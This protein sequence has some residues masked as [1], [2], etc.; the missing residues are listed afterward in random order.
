M[1]VPKHV[2]ESQIASEIMLSQS[3]MSR[4]LSRTPLTNVLNTKIILNMPRMNLLSQS[5]YILYS[6]CFTVWMVS[7]FL[8]NFKGRIGLREFVWTLFKLGL[9]LLDIGWYAYEFLKSKWII[10]NTWLEFIHWL[11]LFILL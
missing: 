6:L 7:Q 11:T 10:W 1:N 5:L 2:K 9:I 4:A 3:T 8:L